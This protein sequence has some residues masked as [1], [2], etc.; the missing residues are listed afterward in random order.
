[1]LTKTQL[2]ILAYLIDNED[3]P[4]GIRE[5]SKRIS[6]V[7]YLV[8][9]NVQQLEKKKIITLQK[10]GKTSLV[11][12]NKQADPVYLIETEKFKRELFYKKYPHFKI[13]LKKIIRQSRS[14]F[15][16]MLVFGSYAKQRPRRDSD[17]DILVITTTQKREELMDRIFSSLKRTSLVKIHETIITEKSFLSMLQKKELSV[18]LEVKEKHILIYGA[19]QYYKLVE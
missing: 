19:E 5:L 17:L 1:M 12:I 7:Y 4:F 16:I 10:A 15:F 14:C 13:V 3:E 9:R 8:Q 2:K 18:A 11:S 6:T